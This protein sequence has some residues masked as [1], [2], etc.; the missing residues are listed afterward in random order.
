MVGSERIGGAALIAGGAGIVLG[1][2]HHP[3]SVAD[4]HLSQWIHGLLIVFLGLTAFGFAA[5]CTAR[6]PTRP[7]ILAGAVAYA[8]AMLGHIGAATVNGFAV[9]VL[10]ARGEPIGR[11]TMLLAW[12][13]NQALA[14]LG[15][16]AAGV[17]FLFWS[18]HLLARKSG[19]SR[20]L[21]ALGL[22]L[23]CGP[24]VLLLSGVISL[25][26]TGAFFA[27]AA[28]AAW[29]AALG[30]HLLRGKAAGEG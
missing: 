27:Y 8:M 21:G 4:A 11:D 26:L 30:I 28:H 10:A 13:I 9:A 5:F 6:G 16:A 19:E 12:D 25:N 24:V 29:G 14:Q 2:G 3:T 20:L 7:A 18:L 17:A 22:L 15:V 23:G 1:M